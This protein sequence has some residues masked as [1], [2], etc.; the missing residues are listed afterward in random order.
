MLPC[1]ICAHHLCVRFFPS[2]VAK[3][4]ESA[5]RNGWSGEYIYIYM[6]NSFQLNCVRANHQ[7]QTSNCELCDLQRNSRLIPCSNCLNDARS[8][9]IC[10][11]MFCVNTIA[12]RH[13]NTRMHYKATRRVWCEKKIYKC[14]FVERVHWIRVWCEMYFLCVFTYIMRVVQV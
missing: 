14:L 7:L 10:E 5:N 1:I 11:I 12:L 4:K 13:E 6:C 8:Q 9:Q 3:T 2:K